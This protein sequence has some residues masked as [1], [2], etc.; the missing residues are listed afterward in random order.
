GSSVYAKA[1]MD[2]SSFGRLLDEAEKKAGVRFAPI[3]LTGWSAGY[4]AVRAILK[5]PE[6]YDRVRFV[7]LLDGLH[8]G[9]VSGKPGPRESSLVA[10]DLEV[11]VKFATDAA[12][13]KKQLIVTHSEVFP[14]TFAST[15]ETSDYLLQRLGLR[16]Q[17][18]LQWGPLK[19]QQLSEARRGGLIVVG[20]AGNTAPDHVD[21]LY[22]LPDFLGWVRLTGPVAN[23]TKG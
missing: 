16:R 15:T 2:P 23:G 20:Y 17:A 5:V 14:G 11:F 1:F 6:N 4:G 9:Y 22:A 19:M 12:A 3:G 10:D 8:A 21:Q 13:G 7:L 18:L